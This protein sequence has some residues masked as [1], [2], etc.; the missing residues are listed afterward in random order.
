LFKRSNEV[1][2]KLMMVFVFVQVPIVFVAESLNVTS[3]MIAN[4]E[5]MQ[6]T[7]VAARQDLSI[8]FFMTYSY[9]MRIMGIFMGL[10]L[11]PLG[12]LF[13]RSAYMNQVIG[14][15][16]ILCGV[17]YVTDSITYLL[18]PQASGI[19][20]VIAYLFSAVAEIS[21][22]LWLLIKGVKDHIYVPVISGAD[23][24]NEYGLLVRP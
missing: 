14:I 5:L 2:A 15:M 8:S 7:S 19:T 21:T 12:E 13:Y 23:Q 22:I 3:L 17:A 4:G 9:A 1:L 11:I 24:R 16:L 10:W 18:F 6:T 20:R